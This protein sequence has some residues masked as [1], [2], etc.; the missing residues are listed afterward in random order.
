[1]TNA[2]HRGN[3]PSGSSNLGAAN[4]GLR[5]TGIPFAAEDHRRRTRIVHLIAH[6]GA[7]Q[8]A[9]LSS[10]ESA[11]SLLEEPHKNRALSSRE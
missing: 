4:F 10:C 9:R 1:M 6:T 7:T 8:F 2:A 3:H 5:S 11:Q